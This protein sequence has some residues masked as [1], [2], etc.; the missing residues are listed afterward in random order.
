VTSLPPGWNEVALRDLCLPV[1]KLDPLLLDRETVRYVD[2]GS[3]DGSRHTVVDVPTIPAVGAPSRCRQIIHSG[4][5]VFSTVRP[6]LEKIAYVDDSLDHEFASTGF[7]VLRP[8]PRLVPKFLYYF[9]ISS[10]MLGQVLPRQKG[11]SYPAVL[12]K[13]VRATTVPV[14]PLEEQRRIVDIIEDH[15]SRLDA[16]ERD[17]R[18]A[19]AQLAPMRRAVWA[20]AFSA[21]EEPTV[22]LLEVAEIANGQTPKGLAEQLVSTPLPG[23]VPFYKVGDMNASDGRWMSGARTYVTTR[24]A[25]DFRLHVRPVGTVLIPKRGGAIA[26]NKK[27]MLAVPATYDLNTMGL[28]ATD[29]LDST[30][31]WHWL[32]GVDLG[33]LADGSSVPQINAAQIRTLSLPVPSRH[34]QASIVA[35]LDETSSDIVRVEQAAA[36]AIK[37]SAAL[38]SALLAAAFSGRL[39]GGWSNEGT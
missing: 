19:A 26:T 1:K 14:P 28:V 35:Q 12:D 31:L 18:R 39:P 16:A 32:Q 29:R 8:G 33:K 24:V 27:R 5:T 34:E 11:V 21:L 9:S 7:C 4:D 20:S 25:D 2:I 38:R 23:T 22:P 13:E 3:V 15:L 17:A 36:Y 10:K 37:R 6:Y 30:F